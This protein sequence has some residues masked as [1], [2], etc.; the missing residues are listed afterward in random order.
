MFGF[1]AID[2]GKDFSFVI[3]ELMCVHA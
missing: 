1:S 3:F 2:F